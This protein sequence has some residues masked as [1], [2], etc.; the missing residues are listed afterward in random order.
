MSPG[1]LL[2]RVGKARGALRRLLPAH[3]LRT[4]CGN[5]IPQSGMVNAGAGSVLRSSREWATNATPCQA[6]L[7]ALCARAHHSP[8]GR[9]RYER[10]HRSVLH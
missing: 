8:H 9:N 2:H 4:H 10:A 3:L 7:A 6:R 1:D 5:D